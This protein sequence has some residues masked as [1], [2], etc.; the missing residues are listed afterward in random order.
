MKGALQFILC[1]LSIPL[2]GQD[3]TI[4]PR[5]YALP[6]T[7]AFDT[8]TSP[9]RRAALCNVDSLELQQMSNNDLIVAALHYPF[10]KVANAFN[11]PQMGYK[12]AAK[13]RD[14]AKKNPINELTSVNKTSHFRQTGADLLAYYKMMDIESVLQD[15]NK[16]F[17]YSISPYHFIQVF[18]ATPQV[19]GQLTESQQR[20]L[21]REA[22]RRYDAAKLAAHYSLVPGSAILLMARILNANS[23]HEF[24]MYKNKRPIKVNPLLEDTGVFVDSTLYPV[25]RQMAV[26][27]SGYVASN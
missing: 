19:Y 22:I 9:T 20:E 26:K 24:I 4:S 23:F 18:L 5:P 1:I 8:V 11:S 14:D 6:G 7:P 12:A 25:I 27:W 10:L 17:N 16:P 2:C 15:Q 13:Y 3:F 21:L